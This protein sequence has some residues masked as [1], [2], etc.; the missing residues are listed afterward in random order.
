M[1]IPPTTS[2]YMRD[3]RLFRRFPNIPM[4]RDAARR[5]LP[6]FAFEY[7]DGGAGT[8]TGIDRNWRALDAVEIVPRYGVCTALPPVDAELFGRRYAGPVGV[9]PMGSPSICFP[10][11]DRML[12]AAAQGALMNCLKFIPR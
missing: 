3:D 12:A 2:L 10:G 7:L 9:A 8:D 11:A 6:R 4:M 5:R 1:T